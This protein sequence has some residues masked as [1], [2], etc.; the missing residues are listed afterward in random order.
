MGGK[1]GQRRLGGEEEDGGT[2]ESG[3]SRGYEKARQRYIWTGT[4]RKAPSSRCRS[5]GRGMTGRKVHRQH[6]ASTFPRLASLAGPG[7]RLVQSWPPVC[8]LLARGHRLPWP[9]KPAR[10]CPLARPGADNGVANRYLEFGPPQVPWLALLYQNQ[11]PCLVGRFHPPITLLPSR[12]SATR[13][14]TR[15]QKHGLVAVAPALALPGGGGF[16]GVKPVQGQVPAPR[17]TAKACR[18]AIHG[19][20]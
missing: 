14:Q 9:P 2:A 19:A 20:M 18:E 3:R 5:A 13:T 17:S 7:G 1:L 11:V 6:V 8:G 12:A 15:H 10:S 4:V 16:G